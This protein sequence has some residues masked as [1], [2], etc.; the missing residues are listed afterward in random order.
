MATSAGRTATR[1][2]RSS[3]L[4]AELPLELTGSRAFPK[5]RVLLDYE[6]KR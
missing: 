3:T 2:M 6:P 1:R 5:G 4:A